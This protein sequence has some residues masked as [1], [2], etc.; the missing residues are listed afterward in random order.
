MGQRRECPL[1]PV[2]TLPPWGELSQRLRERVADRFAHLD[3]E[4]DE[5]SWCVVRITGPAGGVGEVAVE[6]HADLGLIIYVGDFT[7]GHS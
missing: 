2:D 7:H 1:R 4:F 5:P 3:P 6:N